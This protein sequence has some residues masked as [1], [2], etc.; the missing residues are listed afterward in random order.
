MK[1]LDPEQKGSGTGVNT[2][3]PE[4]DVNKDDAPELVLFDDG[5]EV[6]ETELAVRLV[7]CALETLFCNVDVFLAYHTAVRLVWRAGDDKEAQDTNGNSD[8]GADDVHP[9]PTSQAVNTI[10]A[11]GGTSLDQTCRQGSQR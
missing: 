1:A 4:E 9:A 2:S 5:H 8:E 7:S 6:S 10:Q 3:V 11:S